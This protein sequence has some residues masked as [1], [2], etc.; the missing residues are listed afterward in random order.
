VRSRF[1]RIRVA[2][3]LVFC[4]L[5]FVCPFEL[6]V[7][8]VIVRFNFTRS[9]LSVCAVSCGSST[10]KYRLVSS[11]FYWWRKPEYPKKTATLLQVTDNIYHVMLHQ[12]HLESVLNC[13]RPTRNSTNTQWWPSE[14][15][16]M[17]Y[18]FNPQK[19]E[20]MTISRKLK[21]LCCFLWVV[22]N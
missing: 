3:L 6:F 13:R 7:V 12:V 20:T 15:K 1:S 19:T 18:N 21:C 10:I 17:V 14:I 9:S 5:F 11:V 22:Y 4:V 16:C 8:V 2:S